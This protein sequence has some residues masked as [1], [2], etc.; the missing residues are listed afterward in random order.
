MKKQYRDL[1]FKEKKQIASLYAN[2]PSSTMSALARDFDT[3]YARISKAI[4]EAIS[5][6]NLISFDEARKIVQK[7][8]DFTED[9]IGF[10]S[11]SIK[12]I[13]RPLIVERRKKE[14]AFLLEKDEAKLESLEFQLSS[15]E[16]VYCSSDERPDDVISL[17][18]E[19]TRLQKDLDSFSYSDV[20]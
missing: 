16:S 6:P 7:V 3:N 2:C 4:H 10:V 14:I 13:Y 17:I 5:D 18:N 15:F 12:S 19:I 9:K 8:Y 20:S 1:T 11:P